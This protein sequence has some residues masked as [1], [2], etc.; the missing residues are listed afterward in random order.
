M[1]K[2]KE[3]LSVSVAYALTLII[4]AKTGG[5]TRGKIEIHFG[6]SAPIPHCHRIATFTARFGACAR[7]AEHPHLQLHQ[8]LERSPDGVVRNN[9]VSGT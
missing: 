5:L 6:A 8:G 7:R 4:V 2:D 1:V 9:F 3:K